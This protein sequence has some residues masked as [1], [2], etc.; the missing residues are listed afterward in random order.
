MATM[1]ASET[2]CPHSQRKSDR[3]GDDPGPR[4]EVDGQTWRIRSA[5]VARQV[6]R[7]RGATVQAGFVPD[8]VPREARSGVPSGVRKFRR[9]VLFADGEEHRLQRSQIARFFAPRVVKDRYRELMEVRAEKVMTD[10]LRDRVVEL[11]DHTMG[12]A[13]DVASQVVGLTSSNLPRMAARLDEFFGGSRPDAH[14][15]GA[16]YAK[17]LGVLRSPLTRF[18]W[19]D[20]MPAIRER[21]RHRREDVIS[22]L[23]SQGYAN[24]EILAEALTYGA[25]GMVTTREFISM[26][27]WHLIQQPELRER[28]LAAG[29]AERLELLAE[30][31]RLEPVVGHLYR[32]TVEELTVVDEGL[33]WTIPAGVR[34][35]LHV[36]HANADSATVG[37]SADELCP[38][39]GLPKGVAPEVLSFGEGA[40]R[41]PGGPIALQETDVLLRKLLA[42]DLTLLSSPKLVW[43]DLIAG[44]AVTD[45]VLRVRPTDESVPRAA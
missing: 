45:L 43:D 44:Y 22:H 30:V 13:V 40:H 2:R 41:C 28:Y 17:A 27:T 36:R 39:R 26:A 14:P 33:T 34:L 9:P 37:E 4:I 18:F 35:D 38:G 19:F 1:T 5:E 11:S 8:G 20:V 23:I 10:V 7:S 42:C 32:R 16:W 29:E 15:T 24:H 31:L 6:L 12:Y 21:R 25:A 3:P